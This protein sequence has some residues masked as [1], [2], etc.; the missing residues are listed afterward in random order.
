M[1]RRIGWCLHRDVL[2]FQVIEVTR[3]WSGLT[4]QSKPAAFPTFCTIFFFLFCVFCKLI[5][6]SLILGSNFWV[7]R[8]TNLQTSNILFSHV[9]FCQ[10]A[11]GSVLFFAFCCACHVAVFI[12]GMID[13]FIIIGAPL[14]FLWKCPV[15]NDICTV[16]L[17]LHVLS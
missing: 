17:F 2:R 16:L 7:S 9:A 5:A 3:D 12:C 1:N 8:K 14:F 15:H 10:G 11:C 13:L 4:S 6:I